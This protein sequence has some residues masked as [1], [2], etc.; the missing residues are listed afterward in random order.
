VVSVKG[1]PGLCSETFITPSN[2]ETEEVNTKVEEVIYIKE[3]GVPEAITC[4]L[5]ETEPEV[6]LCVCVCA[7]T[8]AC[9]LVCMCI[10][11]CVCVCV[12]GRGLIPMYH[13]VIVLEGVDYIYLAVNMD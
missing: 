7:C 3:E 5:I 4:P 13:E 9:R 10:C 6:R 1:E 2:D 12:C 11:V 8:H